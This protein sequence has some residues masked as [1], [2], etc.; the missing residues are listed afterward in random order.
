MK[1]VYISNHKELEFT[2]RDLIKLD[3]LNANIFETKKANENGKSKYV[4]TFRLGAYVVCMQYSTTTAS[5]F[6]LQRG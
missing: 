6:M 1:H 2:L 5:P 3:K 4:L